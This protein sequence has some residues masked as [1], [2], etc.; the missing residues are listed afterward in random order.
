MTYIM[1]IFHNIIP[2]VHG[3]PSF[4]NEKHEQHHSHHSDHHHHHHST[5]SSDESSFLSRLISALGDHHNAL[6]TDH[7]VDDV[8]VKTNSNNALEGASLKDIVDYPILVIKSNTILGFNLEKII[9]ESPPV[10]YEHSKYC[11]TTLRGPPKF[12]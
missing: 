9:F 5:D 4:D 3:E 2:H 10:L 1:I 12:S 11:T 7:F 6:E 8:L